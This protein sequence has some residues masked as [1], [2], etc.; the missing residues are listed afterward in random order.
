MAPSPA[1]LLRSPTVLTPEAHLPLRKAK[2]SEEVQGPAQWAEWYEP[3]E[4][5]TMSSSPPG[6]SNPTPVLTPPLM[7]L[8]P[9]PSPH[10]ALSVK[11][12]PAP[13]AV[14]GG[15]LIVAASPISLLER[16]RSFDFG[17]MGH[18]AGTP[19]AV[20][21][22]VGAV[23]PGRRKS[24]AGPPSS[25]KKD[26]DKDVKVSLATAAWLE[27]FDPSAGDD[28]S[29]GSGSGAAGS[30]KEGEREGQSN[31]EQVRDAGEPRASENQKM[32][33]VESDATSLTGKEQ[34]TKGLVRVSSDKTD[35]HSPVHD[36]AGPKK[37]RDGVHHVRFDEH[38]VVHHRTATGNFDDMDSQSIL[39]VQG[40]LSS[41]DNHEHD[42][43][44]DG[45]DDLDLEDVAD[46]WLRTKGTPECPPKAEVRT[47]TGPGAT[48]TRPVA[49]DMDFGD[50]EEMSDP[51]RLTGRLELADLG[52][53]DLS[54]TLRRER[55]TEELQMELEMEKERLAQEARHR[56]QDQ[57][58]EQ[59]QE[60]KEASSRGR[61]SSPYAGSMKDS[62]GT[63]EPTFATPTS[64]GGISPLTPIRPLEKI[65][66]LGVAKL[67][68]AT[69]GSTPGRGKVGLRSSWQTGSVK[70][71]VRG[72]HAD[73][74]LWSEFLDEPDFAG[75]DEDEESGLIGA[76]VGGGG[77]D[78]TDLM[79]MGSVI[80]DA[81][82]MDV[83]TSNHLAETAGSAT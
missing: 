53:N 66:H 6:S 11:A 29:K 61:G 27:F 41:K 18:K 81:D 69:A 47:G 51:G 17:V 74:V 57:E 42:D 12:S 32:V 40:Q 33:P 9:V 71:K 5:M 45:D 19:G 56:A 63:P 28:L 54:A 3:H 58:Q 37:H 72:G 2:T 21:P 82:R 67:V 59:E 83:D 79:M 46:R 34:Q 7:A 75:D 36:A 14:R 23:G 44:N 48:P 10:E 50:E 26:K 77:V 62:S 64:M 35:T 68:K 76:G 8:D 4:Q 43:V 22:S 15:P 31:H 65:G 25:S 30:I 16:R 78:A 49:P 70:G 13:V 24:F 80:A 20:A 38:V 55:D 73:P 52:L 39:D 1:D 60:Q